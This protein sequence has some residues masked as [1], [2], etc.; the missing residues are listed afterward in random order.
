MNSIG[1]SSPRSGCCQR[2]SASTARTAPLAE[3]HDRLV[4]DPQLVALERPAQLVLGAQ[5]A[6]DALAQ[7]VVEEL[8]AAAAA[9]LGP[10]H[11][12]VGVADQVGRLG[13]G[14]LGEGDADARR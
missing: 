13:V 12:H 14:V 8:V 11:G 5:P 6:Q 7:H 9:L 2:T 4:E 3:V 10:V 1:R